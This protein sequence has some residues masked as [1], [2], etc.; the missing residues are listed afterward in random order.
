MLKQCLADSRYILEAGRGGICFLWHI[1]SI[2]QHPYIPTK[3][4][5]LYL[6]SRHLIDFGGRRNWKP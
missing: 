4:I 2:I 6:M 1:A 3:P 5:I